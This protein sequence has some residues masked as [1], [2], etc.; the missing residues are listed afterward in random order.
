MKQSEQTLLSLI[1]YAPEEFGADNELAML[2][3]SQ[4]RLEAAE[5]EA[6]EELMLEV[7]MRIPILLSAMRR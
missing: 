2:Y 3:K 6:L 5:K 4:G 1:E 7:A